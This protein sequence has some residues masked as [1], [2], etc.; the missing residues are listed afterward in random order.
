MAIKH[1]EWKEILSTVNEKGNLS[2]DNIIEKI[3]RN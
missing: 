1:E 2:K 3:K